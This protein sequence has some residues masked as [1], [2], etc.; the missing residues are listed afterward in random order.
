VKVGEVSVV[1]GHS[2]GMGGQSWQERADCEASRQ[3]KS[4]AGWL[5]RDTSNTIPSLYLAPRARQT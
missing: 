3:A 1:T 5:S 2:S 4:L